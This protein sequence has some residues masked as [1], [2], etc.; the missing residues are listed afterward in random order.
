MEYSQTG[1]L[2]TPNCTS[3]NRGKAHDVCY[4]LHLVEQWRVDQTVHVENDEFPDRTAVAARESESSIVHA[5]LAS[6]YGD[7]SVQ[8]EWTGVGQGGY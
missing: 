6:G 1:P 8:G 7:L 5:R 2:G 3:C 4:V